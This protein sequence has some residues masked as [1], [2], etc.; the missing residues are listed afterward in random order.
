MAARNSLELVVALFVDWVCASPVGALDLIA[1]EHLTQASAKARCPAPAERMTV[2]PGAIGAC[3]RWRCDG[4]P[5]P[6]EK[7]KEGS[8]Q[9]A[10]L[11]H[12]SSVV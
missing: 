2:L 9:E 5:E 7:D 12:W 6:H 10:M 8:E 11:V 3:S 4:C 1:E